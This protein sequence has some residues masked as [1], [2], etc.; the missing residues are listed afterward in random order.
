MKVGLRVRL[1]T[2]PPSANRL[3]RK[4]G[5][6]DVSQTYGLPPPVTGIALRLPPINLYIYFSCTFSC[7][8]DCRFFI[9][10]MILVLAPVTCRRAEFISHQGQWLHRSNM[11]AHCVYHGLV[12]YALFLFILYMPIGHH[13]YSITIFYFLL[14]LKSGRSQVW[15]MGSP[16]E[17]SDISAASICSPFL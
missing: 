11:R 8:S 12:T 14:Y 2:S 16:R 5:S 6:F 10:Y 3:S 7:R 9:Y 4:C 1:T 17:G 15:I 13:F